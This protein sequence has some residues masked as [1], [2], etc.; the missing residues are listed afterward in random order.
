MVVDAVA[1]FVAVP[2]AVVV[3]VV[4]RGAHERP[5][6][7]Q[8]YCA[9]HCVTSKHAACHEGVRFFNVSTFQKNVPNATR[10]AHV[11]FATRLAPRHFATSEVPKML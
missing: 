11:D 10:F 6:V 1:V 3:V 9:L 5:K 4:P 2:V 8:T 7:L